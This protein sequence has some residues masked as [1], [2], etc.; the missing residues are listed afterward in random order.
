MR[1]GIGK[2]NSKY[3]LSRILLDVMT[4]KSLDRIMLPQH[5]RFIQMINLFF[6][7]FFNKITFIYTIIFY[8]LYKIKNQ[9]YRL[10]NNI[11]K[12]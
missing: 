1:F 4:I 3:G 5:Y 12:N 7:D 10:I 9:V 11:K 2:F 6:F 8:Y